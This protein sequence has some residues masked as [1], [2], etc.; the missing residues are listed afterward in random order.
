MDFQKQYDKSQC[1]HFLEGIHFVLHCHHYNSLMHR[2]I[3]RTPYIDGKKFIFDIAS[4]EFYQTIKQ[5]CTKKN[6]SN[7]KAIIVVAQELYRVL[8]FGYLDM[9]SLSNNGGVIQ[10]DSSHLATGYLTKWGTQK[11]PVDDFGK[12][13]IAATWALAF[14]QDVKNC[15]INQTKCMSCGDS[16][17]EFVIK[18]G[19]F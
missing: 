6:V 12:A 10:T 13:Y 2:A 11:E 4:K 18:Q 16:V 19:G 5:I 8:G 15:K 7:S 3:T 1:K 9:S 17:C 14:N